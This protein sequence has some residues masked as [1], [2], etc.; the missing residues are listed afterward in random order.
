M[1][2][3]LVQL[4]GLSFD[5]G[6]FDSGPVP[7]PG[8]QGMGFL[9]TRAGRPLGR[10]GDNVIAELSM[11]YSLD[12]GVT[13]SDPGSTTLMGAGDYHDR[14]GNP[15]TDDSP[16]W[17]WGAVSPTHLQFALTVYVPF[18]TSITVNQL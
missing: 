16:L 5:V 6:T 8:G 1:T 15:V 4:D 9:L 3:Q 2:T 7:A 14:W 12:D 18:T 13:W 10:E 11:S 17:G